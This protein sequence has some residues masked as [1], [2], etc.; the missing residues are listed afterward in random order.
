VIKTVWLD[1][2]EEELGAAA[3]VGLLTLEVWG[4]LLAVVAG[5]VFWGVVVCCWVEVEGAAVVDG[6]ADEV[7]TALEVDAG[8]SVGVAD[9]EGATEIELRI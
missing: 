9:E 3:E 7:R 4:L 2:D 5:V 8:S 1:E 6:A